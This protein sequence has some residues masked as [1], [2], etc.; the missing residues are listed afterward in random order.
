[1]ALVPDAPRRARGRV[2]YLNIEAFEIDKKIPNL[3]KL[4]REG[5]TGAAMD[6]DEEL[7]RMRKRVSIGTS[8]L[9][10]FCR[11]GFSDERVCASTIEG[12]CGN[13]H[14]LNGSFECGGPRI[15]LSLR[16]KSLSSSPKE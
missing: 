10:Q 5:S 15:Y 6:I 13:T 16:L 4:G 3:S 1:M 7:G 11:C 2:P 14:G 8:Y 12:L 9:G